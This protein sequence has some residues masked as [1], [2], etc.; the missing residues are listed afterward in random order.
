[1]ELGG[2]NVE[3]GYTFGPTW[4][5][6]F[7]ELFL[8]DRGVY[9]LILCLTLIIAARNIK[10]KKPRKTS[11]LLILFCSTRLNFSPFRSSSSIFGSVGERLDAMLQ[12]NEAQI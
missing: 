9:L 4:S 2:K 11:T 12:K 8:S 1:M 6:F 10:L 3:D 5:E 7:P